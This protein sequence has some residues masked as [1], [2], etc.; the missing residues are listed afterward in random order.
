MNISVLT[1]FPEMLELFWQ[2]GM[3]KR[4]IEQEIIANGKMA[5]ADARTV[6]GL[7]EQEAIRKKI[8]EGRFASDE[9]LLTLAN[10]LEERRVAEL[11][12]DERSLEL[13]QAEIDKQLEGFE[14]TDELKKKQ[15][16]AKTDKEIEDKKA[17]DEALLQL[18]KDHQL[19]VQNFL[20]D[21]EHIGGAP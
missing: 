6:A 9:A 14:K 18:E 3:I 8:A 7:K 1:I 17:K 10:R 19:R 21:T 12:D 2:N 5:T 20:A 16:Q 11:T 13:L 15:E 4:A